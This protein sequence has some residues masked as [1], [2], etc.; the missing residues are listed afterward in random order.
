MQ[1]G[2]HYVLQQDRV[3]AGMVTFWIQF[4][5]QIVFGNCR[6]A[7]EPWAEAIRPRLEIVDC[8]VVS[9]RQICFKDK[10]NAASAAGRICLLPYGHGGWIGGERSAMMVGSKI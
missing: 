6:V 7:R 10:L 1:V 9:I 3:L 2:Q 4:D 5:E 8:S